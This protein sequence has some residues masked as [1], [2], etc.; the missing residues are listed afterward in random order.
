MIVHQ[1]FAQIY[2]GAV[3]NIIVCEDYEMANYLAR[4]TYGEEAF[5]VNC[6]QYPCE[7]GDSY[8]DNKFYRTDENGGER[9]IQYIPTQEQQVSHLIS[10]GN[11]MAEYQIEI[12]YRLSCQQLKL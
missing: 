8:H 11:V 2:E 7:P 9:E 1:V 4:A 6:I 12:D 10:E 5:A 3:K